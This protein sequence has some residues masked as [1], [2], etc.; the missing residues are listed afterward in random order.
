VIELRRERLDLA[1]V[2]HTAV[3]TCEPLIRAAGHLLT[4]ALPAEPLSLE[5]DPVRLTQVFANLIHNAVKY[6]SAGGRIAVTARQE[7]NDAV[8]SVRDNGIGIPPQELLNVFDP[9]TQVK[10][11]GSRARDG[12]GIGLSLVARLVALHGGRIEAKSPGVGGGSEFVVRLPLAAGAGD[13]PGHAVRAV[14]SADPWP[15]LRVMVVDD[16]RDAGDSL[17]AMLRLRGL[18]VQVVPDGT[19]A[20]EAMGVFRPVLILLDIGM[21]GMDGYEVARRIRQRPEGRTVTL[22]GLTGW[23]QPADRRRGWEAGFDHHLVKPARLEELDR[24]LAPLARSAWRGARASDPGFHLPER[25][26]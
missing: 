7:G 19:T 21:P 25:E 15:P 5:A 23:G 3:E 17:G 14:S 4:V 2:I 6:T 12:L 16:D 18:D 20:I 9:F 11:A 1:A 24:I 8:V 22:V 10:A 26:G 13:L